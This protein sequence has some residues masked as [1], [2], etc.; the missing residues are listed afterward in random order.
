MQ[1]L[2]SWHICHWI[3]LTVANNCS[4]YYNIHIHLYV[5][6]ICKIR[7]K[8]CCGQHNRIL[9]PSAN[10]VSDDLCDW[11]YHWFCRRLDLNILL[12]KNNS[13]L[14]DMLTKRIQWSPRQIILFLTFGYTVIW[15]NDDL[16]SICCFVTS[17]KWHF[18]GMKIISSR[19]FI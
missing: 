5:G 19:K 13:T 18:N 9:Y 4:V 10:C 7:R 1:F 15:T 14:M 11:S 3:S 6:F 17:R 2:A 16:L 8:G 12:D